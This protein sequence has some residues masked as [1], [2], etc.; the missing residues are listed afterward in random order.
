M[1]TDVERLMWN[2]LSMGTDWLTSSADPEQ[3]GWYR[4][5]SLAHKNPASSRAMPATT[6]LVE[7]L[8]AARRQKRPHRRSW[9]APAPRDYLR[10]QALLAAGDLNTD[11]WPVLAGPGRL[12]QLGA[13]VGVAGL[14]RWPRTVRW[15][16]AGSLGPARRS[17]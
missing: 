6:T 14:M 8:R 13:Q 12:D 3:V 5:G 17:P 9:A 10:V 1:S 11:P 15:P 4:A 7:V 16:L 2:D